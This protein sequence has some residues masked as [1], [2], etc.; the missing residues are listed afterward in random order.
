MGAQQ[1]APILFA[2]EKDKFPL[3]KPTKNCYNGLAVKQ[4][5]RWL[6]G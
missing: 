6:N 4:M 1:C 2:A 5:H 3:Y